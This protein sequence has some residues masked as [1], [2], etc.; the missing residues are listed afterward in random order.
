MKKLTSKEIKKFY[1]SV[2]TNLEQKQYLT[3]QEIKNIQ[4][5]LDYKKHIESTTAFIKLKVGSIPIDD[6]M[7]YKLAKF[8]K[9]I[10]LPNKAKY[11]ISKITPE[12]LYTIQQ[13]KKD[14]ANS[15]RFKQI[16]LKSGIDYQSNFPR[17]DLIS[18]SKNYS[19]NQKGK[20]ITKL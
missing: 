11:F 15:S 9:I 19:N 8:C 7:R 6:K 20:T 18:K 16:L 4:Q 14:I 1:D 5:C 10:S 3:E 13:L 12:S 2:L 17:T